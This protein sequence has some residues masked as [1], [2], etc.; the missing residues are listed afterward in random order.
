MKALG[1]LGIG[2]PGLP[3]KLMLLWWRY[4]KHALNKDLS[5]TEIE[6]LINERILSDRDRRIMK[7][8][9]LDHITMEKIAEEFDLSTRGTVKIIY[10]CLN[11]LSR[12][13]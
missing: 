11:I 6:R 4:M 13:V 12:Y 10:R 5:Y 8:R 7:R 9:L 3:I 1:E 2:T